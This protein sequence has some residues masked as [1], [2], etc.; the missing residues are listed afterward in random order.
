MIKHEACLLLLLFQY[1]VFFKNL[2]LMYSYEWIQGNL[3][4]PTT[5]HSTL[6][7]AYFVR[8]RASFRGKSGL[9]GKSTHS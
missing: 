8:G 9:A 7:V 1:L 5:V 6:W 3:P 4:I 2:Q